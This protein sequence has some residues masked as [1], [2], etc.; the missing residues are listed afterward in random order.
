MSKIAVIFD[1]NACRSRRD[2]QHLFGERQILNEIASRAVIL[3]PKIVA[4]ELIQQNIEGTIENI[5]GLKRNTLLSELGF[6]NRI[7]DTLD[8]N[9]HAQKIYENETITHRVVELQNLEKVFRKIESWSIAGNA[10]FNE[11]TKDGKNNSDKGF[12]D[13]I[14]A[15]TIDEIIAAKEFDTYY[16]ACHDSRLKDYFKDNKNITCLTPK[17]ILD[18]LKKEFFDEYT[19]DRVKDE[20]SWPS[21]VLKND[22]ININLDIVGQFDY[23]EYENLIIFDR[24]SKEIIEITDFLSIYDSNIL[25]LSGSFSA[26]HEAVAKITESI[27]YYNQ[28]ELLNVKLGL[29]TN[30]QVYSIGSDDD[31]KALAKQIYDYFLYDL[32]GEEKEIFARYY[33]MREKS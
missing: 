27:N 22:W 21:I 7:L 13:A 33:N 30:D 25:N 31:V 9:I 24:T 6:D 4:D 20:L 18:E 29:T 11:R 5:E 16:L 19:L 23:E 32:T 12:K 26:T 10:P 28:D 14:V 8:S 1:T 3:V 17:E 15:C 2:T